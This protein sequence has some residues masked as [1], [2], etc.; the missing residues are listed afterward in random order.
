[1]KR[2]GHRRIVAGV[3]ALALNAALVSVLAYTQRSAPAPVERTFE[4][5]LQRAAGTQA[6]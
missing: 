4:I 6:A 3:A 5:N 2:P 1:M